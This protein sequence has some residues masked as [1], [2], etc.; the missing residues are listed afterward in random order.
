MPLLNLDGGVMFQ[1]PESRIGGA[2][3]WLSDV[4]CGKWRGGGCE[5]KPNFYISNI[6]LSHEH[7]TRFK[8]VNG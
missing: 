1:D 5:Y 8:A 2:L 7:S 3:L 6:R 4:A